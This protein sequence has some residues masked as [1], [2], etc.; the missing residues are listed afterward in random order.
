VNAIGF[1]V[2]SLSFNYLGVPIFKGKPKARYFYLIA[3]KIKAK[4]GAWK[5]FILSIAGRVQLF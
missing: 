1:K 4:L 2:G 3:D 5:A